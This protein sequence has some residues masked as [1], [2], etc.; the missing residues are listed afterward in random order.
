MKL[1]CVNFWLLLLWSSMVQGQDQEQAYSSCN[2]DSFCICKNHPVGALLPDC[3]DCSGYFQCG[4]DNIQKLKCNP[5]EIFDS[6]LTACVP[7]TCP[8]SD[9]S[10]SAALSGCSSKDEANLDTFCICKDHQVGDLLP[11]CDDCSGYFLCGEDI[12]QRLK[13]NQGEIFDSSLSACVPGQCPRN[14]CKNT[15]N[16]G[17][18]E[19]PEIPSGCGNKEVQCRFHGQILP[20]AQHCRFFWTCVEG[21]PMLGFCELG[22]WFDREKFVC[23][24]PNNVSNCPINQD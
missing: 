12:I 14:D 20:H 23:R 6:R 3:D 1:V 22:M 2:S 13:C 17:D 15:T 18:P 10:R 21:C 11:D 24:Y 16:P 4:L 19:D 5:G 7:G 9:C 8:R